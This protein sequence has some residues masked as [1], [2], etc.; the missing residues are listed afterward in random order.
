MRF[1]PL[2]VKYTNGFSI[3]KCKG[4]MCKNSPFSLQKSTFLANIAYFLCLSDGLNGALY[5]QSVKNQ[6]YA[7]AFAFVPF[8]RRH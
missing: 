6:L 2:A 1:S 7:Q 8:K 4:K 3:R 5:R